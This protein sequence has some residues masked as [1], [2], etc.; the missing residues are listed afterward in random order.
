M[1][2]NG[3]FPCS[4]LYL[5]TVWAERVQEVFMISFLNVLSYMPFSTGFSCEENPLPFIPGDC[6]AIFGPERHVVSTTDYCLAIV[7]V[8]VPNVSQAVNGCGVQSSSAVYAEMPS[9]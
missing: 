8:Y 7:P 1:I 4:M 2:A 3:N 6:F 5:L 9:C